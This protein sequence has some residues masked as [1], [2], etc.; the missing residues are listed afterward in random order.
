M[1]TITLSGACALHARVP[2]L[3]LGFALF[4]LT[5]YAQTTSTVSEVDRLLKTGSMSVSA[6]LTSE[7]YLPLHPDKEFRALIRKYAP[8]GKI[9]VAT[10][11]EPGTRIEIKGRIQGEDQKPRANV[12]FYF[13]HTMHNGL[14]AEGGN[15]LQ[16]IA[17]LFGYLRTDNEGQ[18]VINTIKPAGYP[19]ERFPSH[20]HVE[21]YDEA[22]RIILRTELQ[23]EDDSRLDKATRENSIRHGN[24]ISSNTGSAN[25]PVYAY[26]VV[27]PE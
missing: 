18:F 6:V 3:S 2:A 26:T 22:G 8:Q 11:T 23:F 1:K 7:K 14:Y 21:V 13:Y 27:L 15:G 19:G 4:C 12:L 17:K 25:K 24:L 5:S 16:E 10:P 20:V 9:S